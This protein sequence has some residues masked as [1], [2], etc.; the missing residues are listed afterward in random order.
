MVLQK[1]GASDTDMPV[2][3]SGICETPA[4]LII[5]YVNQDT[6]LLK[7]RI[8]EFCAKRNLEESLFCSILRQLDVERVQ[9]SKNIEDYSEGQ[10]K[11]CYLRQVC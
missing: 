4:G 2:V 7:G 11:R 3:E 8:A 9:F 10:K 5:S 1:A 6:S